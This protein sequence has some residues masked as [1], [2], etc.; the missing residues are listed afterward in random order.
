MICRKCH[1]KNPESSIY[2][3]S[4]GQPLI[5]KPGAKRK[6]L[7]WYVVFACV[8]VLLLGGYFL[9][10]ML[11]PASEKDMSSDTAASQGKVLRVVSP[12]ITDNPLIIGGI[13][14]K[15]LEGSEIAGCASAVFNDDWVAAPVWSLL[16]GIDLVFQMSGS[17]EI[18]LKEAVWANGNPIILMK[19]QDE[20]I[21]K[22]PELSPWKQYQSLEWLPSLKKEGGYQVNIPPPEKKGMFL[23]FPLPHEI[24]ES[25]VFMQE[26]QVV[27]WAFP[28]WLD[29]GYLWGGPEGSDLTPGIQMNQFFRS[30]L[31]AW[32][33]TH[34]A[35]ILNKGEDILSVRKLEALAEGLIMDS[36][37]SDEDVPQPLRTQSI[38]KHMHAIAS[39]LMQNGLAA[40]VARILDEHIISASPNLTLVKD[41]VLARVEIED[42]RKAIQFLERIKKN[43]Y[44]VKGQGIS[45]LSQFHAELYKD[46]LRNILDQGG[47][48][49][50]RAAF[51]EAKRHFPD[52]TELHL[53]GVEIA[54]A[55]KE[56]ARARELLQMRD[57]PKAMREWVGELENEIQEVQENE[58][59]ATIRFNPGAMHIP[60]KVYL[61]GNHSFRF[62][63]D[64]G[65]TMCSIPSSAVDR[66]RLDI[67]QT[68]PTR[69]ISTAGGVAE[70]YEVDL[71]SIELEGFRVLGV[72]ALIIDIP[73]YRDYGLLG[74]NF[75]NNF[76]IEIDSQE[77]ILR[78]K[79]R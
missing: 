54:L 67:D 79:K 68:T 64:T 53:L 16:G 39:D 33:E 61:N 70:T 22:T 51:E 47:Y 21:R 12:D 74:Q 17:A 55:D 19:L 30:T 32:R 40:E 8:G 57:Y 60:V 65:A 35:N 34:F 43:F 58:G 14:V 11:L 46:W 24:Q 78:L 72:K 15:D 23:S 29:N 59:A 37:F 48:Y 28:D 50:G 2:C 62:I 26:G 18:P 31:A 52:D 6:S 56:W 44:A 36:R 1:R 42:F 38:I 76:H 7:S 63:L 69:L 75:L 27:G 4:C 10:R 13:I 73:G 66:L 45:G 41:S 25:G 20:A 5:R 3:D 49:S 71:K 77:G 9:I